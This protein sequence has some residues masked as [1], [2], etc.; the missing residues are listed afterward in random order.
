[1]SEHQ[2]NNNYYA[3]MKEEYSEIT[4]TSLWKYLEKD[5]QGQ[6]YAMD[7]SHLCFDACVIT[8]SITERLPKFTKHD[9]HHIKGV[10]D[11][12]TKLLD[13]KLEVLKKEEVALLIM[14]A[15]CHDVGMNISEKNYN[16]LFNELE[17]ESYARDLE[18]YF[19]NNKKIDN[20]YKNRDKSSDNS[21]LYNYIIRDFVRKNHHLRVKDELLS[22]SFE[23]LC[24][25]FEKETIL[26]LCQSHGED[27]NNIM[28]YKVDTGIRIYL[29]AI[30]LRLADILDFDISRS[31]KAKY[32]QSG[33]DDPQTEEERINANEHKKNQTCSWVINNDVV[34][35]TGECENN[36]LMHD[37]F[38]Y[39]EW[40]RQ[41]VASCNDLLNRINRIDN[42]IVI[43][44]VKTKLSGPFE[45]GNFKISVDA[46]R[47]IRLLGSER[48]YGDKRAFLTELIQNSYDAILVRN[49]VDNNFSIEKGKIDIYLWE[50]EDNVWV[51][52]DDNG[53]GMD[54]EIIM[55]YF[56]T[57]GESYYKSQEFKR[58]LRESQ[59]KFTPINGF[60]IGILSCFMNQ[61]K[62]Y[63]EIETR[64]IINKE[65]YRMDITSL[66]GYYSLYKLDRN[67]TINP[68]SKP[69]KEAIK[70]GYNRDYGTSIC[71]KYLK[72]EKYNVELFESYIKKRIRFPEININIHKEGKVFQFPQ[73]QYVLSLLKNVMN[74]Q[75][76]KKINDIYY[77]YY[78]D[79]LDDI[80]FI[81]KT[82][83]YKIN[84]N[85][86][87]DVSIIILKSE[88]ERRY[89]DIE[90]DI[91]DKNEKIQ[92][93]FRNEKKCS[94]DEL[95]LLRVLSPTYDSGFIPGAHQ[96]VCNGNAIS[97]SE[98]GF[99]YGGAIYYFAGN[100]WYEKTNISKT[101]FIDKN[102]HFSF[103]RDLV[104]CILHSIISSK[105]P[106]IWSVFEA[107]KQRTIYETLNDGELTENRLIKVYRLYTFRNFSC[108]YKVYVDKNGILSFDKN[109]VLDRNESLFR[110][111][112]F[113]RAIVFPS[114]DAKE[115]FF[116]LEDNFAGYHQ[117]PKEELLY[118]Y[119]WEDY[120]NGNNPFVN[121][122]LRKHELLSDEVIKKLFLLWDKNFE[123]YP[124]D[125]INLKKD[126]ADFI[127]EMEK[128]KSGLI[129]DC[130]LEYKKEILDEIK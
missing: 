70:D 93:K 81:D 75:N 127:D 112:M 41:E 95:E 13:N 121:W 38:Q 102:E 45:S 8:E 67:N 99:P 104:A 4:N 116:G 12:M 15:C 88:Y 16:L 106:V 39:V 123:I 91:N 18:E 27:L 115:L 60:G 54:K 23:G 87:Q 17:T 47:I 76:C 130:L 35:C 19:V 68:L 28:D 30:L 49:C 1:M 32:Y 21:D 128:D 66:D 126:I 11:W 52:V 73:K 40:V 6:I 14:I 94:E 113:Q 5:P 96:I 111:C 108:M 24:G 119:G 105:M 82:V 114:F 77:L 53:M 101:V 110:L 97:F 59:N 120:I 46:K 7:I 100:D 92:R 85:D 84:K 33:L 62:V 9:I 48:I 31:P 22:D 50:D 55:N 36:Q 44:Q 122:I 83:Q 125:L 37:V 29:L 90:N 63:M 10:C 89:E 107:I 20:E 42:P 25:V 124:T 117:M 118:K 43:K 65:T 80:A 2:N 3:R 51:R 26:R 71:L 64:N 61:T 58:I 74:G 78:L 56:L 57:A 109:N 79:K 86:F 69:N 103:L 34:L 129:D 98:P 72:D